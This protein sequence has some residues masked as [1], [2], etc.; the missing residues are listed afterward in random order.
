MRHDESG[1]AKGRVMLADASAGALTP[2]VVDQ[3]VEDI[4]TW[5]REGYHPLAHRRSIAHPVT[6][7][8]IL[9]GHAGLRQPR[10]PE[11]T[12]AVRLGPERV[13]MVLHLE[14]ELA[15]AVEH[16]PASPL[17]SGVIAR[18]LDIRRT[19]TIGTMVLNGSLVRVGGARLKP[20][21]ITP[22]GHHRVI[23]APEV[24]AAHIGQRATAG[25]PPSERCID[26][27]KLAERYP[28]AT[29]TEPG[30]VV[31]ALSPQPTALVDERGFSV[32]EFPAT[33]LRLSSDSG[34]MTP[35]VLAALVE[36]ASRSHHAGRPP[37]GIRLDQLHL[38]RLGDD[39]MAALDD[40]LERAE[41][42]RRRARQEL[43]TLDALCDTTLAG[44]A[45]GTLTFSTVT[46]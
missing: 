40:L 11:A 26:R 6:I 12:E 33:V 27:A 9:D 31:V 29:L 2:T 46:T 42:R 44:L 28:R 14:A 41:V 15:G 7:G 23:G 34:A 10:R 35:R 37:R 16:A 19:V 43:D 13:A 39:E 5:R 30:D 32:V 17:R 18:D 4:T 36:S 1:H 3:L 25:A 24:L 38:P 20:D 45:D 21:H 22:A 8:D